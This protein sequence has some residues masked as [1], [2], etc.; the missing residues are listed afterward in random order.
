MKCRQCSAILADPKRNRTGLC[1][2]CSARENVKIS[3][4]SI[5]GIPRTEETKERIRQTKIAEKNP[6]WRGDS[7]GIHQLHTWVKVRLPKPKKCECCKKVPPYDLANKGIYDRNLENWEW[8]CR[9]CHM[10]KDGRIKQLAS[11]AKMASDK[12]AEK[13]RI[14]DG[15]TK[16]QRYYRRKCGYI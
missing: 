3:H 2:P 15:L 8:L 14:N 9:R 7:V 12:S 11:Q 6:M 1:R 16:Y 4:E 10:T 13:S 5:R